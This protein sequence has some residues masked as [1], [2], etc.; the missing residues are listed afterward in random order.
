MGKPT[1]LSRAISFLYQEYEVRKQ[2]RAPYLAV[3]ACECEI[4]PVLRR[5]TFFGGSSWRCYGV[6]CLSDYSFSFRA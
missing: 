4:W 6:C 1:A 5:P 2:R 3:I